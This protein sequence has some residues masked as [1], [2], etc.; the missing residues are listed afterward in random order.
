MAIY[1]LNPRRVVWF[2]PNEPSNKYD[3]WLSRNA[4]L[5]ENGEPTTDSNSQRDC[6]YI[7]KIY[8]CG[9]WNPIVGFNS[10][11]ANKIDTV[12]G[13]DYTID[14]V[15]H[16]GKE[17]YHPAIFT[18]ESP[19]ELYDAGTLGSLLSN[20][21]F[22]SEQ[23]WYDVFNSTNYS[24][25][26]IFGDT[27][28]FGDLI[29]E[30]IQ[31]GSSTYH[32]PFATTERCG[33][34]LSATHPAASS[35]FKPIEVKFYP[36][37]QGYYQNE[38]HRL[39]V[40]ASDVIQ[41]INNYYNDNPG[42]SSININWNSTTIHQLAEVLQ[43]V[44]KNS[45]SLGFE[46]VWSLANDPHVYPHIWGVNQTNKG[47]FLK[48]KDVFPSEGSGWSQ[49]NNA[50]EWVDIK[51]L[52]PDLINQG[53]MF[54]PADGISIAYVAPYGDDLQYVKWG[55]NHIGQA[56][57]GQ[58]CRKVTNNGVVDIEWIGAQ[59]IVE[60]GLGISSGT[61][62]LYYNDGAFVLDPG[63]G[64][65]GGGIT[66]YP[67][68]LSNYNT[69]GNYVIGVSSGGTGGNK[70]YLNGYGEWSVP[71]GTTYND[72]SGSAHGLVPASTQQT[73]DKYL[74]GDG[75][76]GVPSVE[77]DFEIT[78][79]TSIEDDADFTLN[80]TLLT[81]NSASNPV[82]E[83]LS[84][85]NYYNIDGDNKTVQFTFVNTHVSGNAIYIR[86]NTAAAPVT[87]NTDADI[88]LSNETMSSSRRQFAANS[89]YLI[90]I[91]FGII[92]IEKITVDSNSSDS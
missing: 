45:S 38:Q 44:F 68:S 6:D 54:I 46:D 5:D 35:A 59:T 29:W 27:N 3:I 53:E 84:E 1:N 48:I 31:G 70:K 25:D 77:A 80:D 85:W 13:V 92:K 36:T 12:T 89:S 91:Q 42:G 41:Q 57:D 61:G 60:E 20:P 67:L 16:S 86:F 56:T 26:N 22:V 58:F 21:N 11:A 83:R 63:T 62:Y 50:V 51:E 55:L 75:T 37:V 69:A 32:L 87:I 66:Y 14:G 24:W 43:D 7:F 10:T 73:Q 39:C 79:N 9:K 40:S 65:G 4:H 2:S 49:S 71:E 28:W 82:N 17:I 90:T 8:D 15:T 64:G 18:A 30:T 47:K 19:N 88:I 78:L 52:L 72:F 74:K 76:W 33:G 81:S 34:I 23:E